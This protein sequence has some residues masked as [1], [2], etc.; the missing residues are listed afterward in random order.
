MNVRQ[1][2]D[3]E[4]LF[5][6]LD[7][8]QTPVTGAIFSDLTADF[9]IP[10]E[11]AF[12][13]RAVPTEDFLEI[14][15]GYYSLKLSGQNDLN[16]LGTYFLRLSALTSEVTEVDLTV[17]TAPIG[18]DPDPA[19]CVVSGNITDIGGEPGEG[20]QVTFRGA[21]FPVQTGGTSIITSDAIRTFP[22]AQGNFSVKLLREQTVI[23]KIDRTGIE[24]QFEVPDQETA[25]IL[26]LLPPIP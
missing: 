3:F 15:L 20:Q 21:D 12:Q 2:Q 1:G 10:G 18:I 11:T 14:G 8:T 5:R 26:D 25:Q 6:L 16:S 22:D 4:L 23:V 19:I 13:T 17:E 24:N 9:W 7:N